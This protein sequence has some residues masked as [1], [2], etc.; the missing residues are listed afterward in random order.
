M[1][2]SIFLKLGGNCQRMGPSFGRRGWTRR[3]TQKVLTRM[4]ADCAMIASSHPPSR[5]GRILCILEQRDDRRCVASRSL[6]APL[7][8]S[9]GWCAPR[10]MKP[11]SSA[12]VRHFPKLLVPN[13][14]ITGT[15]FRPFTG[16]IATLGCLKNLNCHS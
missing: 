16:V 9:T 5:G 15:K 12:C 3:E 8:P 4:N 13:W 2:N 7:P 1:A 10:A 14:S 11:E 6:S